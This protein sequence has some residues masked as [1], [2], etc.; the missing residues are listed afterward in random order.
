METSFVMIR[1]SFNYSLVSAGHL[2][3]TASFQRAIFQLQPRFSGPSFNYSLVSAGHLSPTASFRHL[4]L[5]RFSGPSFNYSLVSAGHLSTTAS[6][7]RAISQLQPRFSG[8]SPDRMRS[9]PDRSVMHAVIHYAFSPIQ[10][11]SMLGHHAS[12]QCTYC[13][14]SLTRFRL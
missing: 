8:P 6:F 12:T 14:R 5:Q 2:S 4:S 7:Q 3:T 10:C 9:S 13:I 11:I 1:P